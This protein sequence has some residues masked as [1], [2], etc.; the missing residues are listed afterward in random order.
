VSTPMRID[1]LPCARNGRPGS[2]TID[3][4]PPIKTRREMVMPLLLSCGRFR[5]KAAEIGSTMVP[6]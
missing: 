5:V 2:P 3:A 1:W 4:V 6:A